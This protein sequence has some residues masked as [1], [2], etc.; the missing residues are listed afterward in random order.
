MPPRREDHAEGT[1]WGAFPHSDAG[2]AWLPR[3]HGHLRKAARQTRA[4]CSP[5][6][7]AWR[8][9]AGVPGSTGPGART[10]WRVRLQRTRAGTGSGAAPRRARRAATRPAHGPVATARAGSVSRSDRNNTRPRAARAGPGALRH[11][12]RQR[13]PAPGRPRRAQGCRAGSRAPRGRRHSR[14]PG[15]RRRGGLGR[16]L[17]GSGTR[18]HQTPGARR[19]R[20]AR[21]GAGSGPRRPTRA[22][23]VHG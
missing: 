5:L 23:N 14:G 20:T 11:S 13:A 21:T 9:A 6:A 2:H 4:V 7:T 8:A 22:A 15:R 18:K 3:V 10:V 16:A 12:S 17:D 19:S 1:V